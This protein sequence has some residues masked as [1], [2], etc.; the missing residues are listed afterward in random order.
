MTA[1]TNK[2]EIMF[3]SLKEPT[4]PIVVMC[5]LKG[6]HPSHFTSGNMTTIQKRLT[7]G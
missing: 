4:E 6:N 2:Y 5:V 7:E 3:M 1:T